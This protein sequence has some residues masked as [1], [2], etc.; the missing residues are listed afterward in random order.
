MK[1]RSAEWF[2][3][4]LGKVTGSRIADVI[5]KT[6]TGYGAARERYKRDII[7]ERLSGAVLDRYVSQPMMWG[8]ETEPAARAAYEART[9]SMVREV[10]FAPHPFIAMAGVSPDGLV[11]DDGCIEIKCPLT[12]T[13][14][15]TLVNKTGVKAYAPQIQWQMACTGR[16][17]CDFISYDPRLPDKLALFVQRVPRDDA[18]IDE[19]TQ[20]V[21]KFLHEVDQTIAS[22]QKLS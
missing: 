1:Q 10:G 14:V 21:L 15:D 17:W 18:L 9:G 3:A 12:A 13:H 5:A 20:E 8:I 22:L 2:E 11:D 16:A 19:I 4:R 7:A 6:K